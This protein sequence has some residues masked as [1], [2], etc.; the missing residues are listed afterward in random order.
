MATKPPP[1]TAH[2][3][4]R[5][6]SMSSGN[7]PPP[8]PPKPASLSSGAVSTNRST[9]SSSF[10]QGNNKPQQLP[11]LATE[12]TSSNY[13]GQ[14]TITY[15]EVSLV[16][17]HSHEDLHTRSRDPFS[18]NQGSARSIAEYPWTDVDS[19]LGLPHNFYFKDLPILMIR[20]SIVY[21]HP[22]L[23][24]CSNRNGRYR[25]GEQSCRWD[26]LSVFRGASSCII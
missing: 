23:F 6:E 14:N 3:P 21:S 20:H 10:F 25:M 13:H 24:L 8:Y 11:N 5:T 15:E 1:S 16:S 4:R 26:I 7:P 17:S 22:S 19:D 18:Q 12:S 2:Q 9:S